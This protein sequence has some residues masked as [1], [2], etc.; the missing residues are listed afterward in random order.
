M[1]ARSQPI[2][3]VT[4]L[5]PGSAKAT[6]AAGV[7][8]LRPAGRRRQPRGGSPSRTPTHGRSTADRSTRP[9]DRDVDDV[10]VVDLKRIL[11]MY[12]VSFLS[13]F[14][15]CIAAYIYIFIVQSFHYSSSRIVLYRSKQQQLI[16][17]NVCGI[18]EKT[19]F[20]ILDSSFSSLF[21]S[22]FIHVGDSRGDG[23]GLLLLLL[24][25]CELLLRCLLLPLLLL[26][27]VT[28]F[29][30]K[31]VRVKRRGG[32]FRLLIGVPS[33]ILLVEI[34]IP[35][36]V[37]TPV[38]QQPGQHLRVVAVQVVNLK[39]TNFETGFSLYRFEG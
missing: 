26:L 33:G 7:F 5:T 1:T 10:D 31:V 27:L 24:L 25:R 15:T 30:E 22:L 18:M 9:L 6:L 32:R 35:L 20:F 28:G 14:V 12:Y 39:S 23:G 17:D 13:F 37:G 36:K 2:V 4:N 29:V 16:G 19:L 11:T 34:R 38:G 3:Y 8:T 21:A